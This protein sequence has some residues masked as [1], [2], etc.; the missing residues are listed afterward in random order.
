MKSFIKSIPQVM[1][2]FNKIGVLNIIRQKG[3][4]SRAELSRVTQLK[5]P[6]ISIIVNN[7]I[8][9][10]FIKETGIGADNN[11]LGRKPI[12]LELNPDKGYVIGLE[13]GFQGLIGL[14]V[15]L[16]NNILHRI[17]RPAMEGVSQSEL[18]LAMETMISELIVRSGHG[19]DKIL[20][21][22]IGISGRV[23]YQRGLV[24]F[25]NVFQGENLPLKERIEK[26]TGITVFLDSNDNVGALAEKWL[27]KGQH[28][29]DMFYLSKR[30]SLGSAIFVNGNLYRGLKNY[31]G[32]LTFLV[33]PAEGINT[34][35]RQA[36]GAYLSLSALAVADLEK[37]ENSWI[38]ESIGGD[39][40]KVTD[41]LVFEAA[42]Q[43][44]PLAL[45]LVRW[46]GKHFGVL[47]AHVADLL[48]P[49]LMILGGDFF[50][51]GDL[52]L[53]TV[54]DAFRRNASQGINEDVRV[55]LS[56]LGTDAI[57]LGGTALVMEN[58]FTTKERAG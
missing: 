17:T 35:P 10:G 27:G 55:E 48:S 23:D 51:G 45:R 8:Q 18:I 19:T 28:V 33:E 25:S 2:R 31:A 13:I 41:E 38:R 24:R 32:E 34:W 47:L 56:A 14:L 15:D 3:S 44:D 9:E 49:E 39:F 58:I 43:N 21:I 50:L 36:Y 6:S 46:Y 20:G 30:R 11:V 53:D 16:R 7:L 52:L 4:I 5:K 54:R 29:Q 40:S 1:G 42:R 57:A 37:G 26:D 22:G 12:M